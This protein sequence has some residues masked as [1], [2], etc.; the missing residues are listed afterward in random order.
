VAFFFSA[1]SAKQP[2]KNKGKKQASAPD[3]ESDDSNEEVVTS[4]QVASNTS[5]VWL[6]NHSTVVD[7]KLCPTI[8]YWIAVTTPNG[9]PANPIFILRALLDCDVETMANQVHHFNVVLLGI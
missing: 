6:S 8:N 5:P 3:P 9:A 1:M 4:S 7:E 2:T